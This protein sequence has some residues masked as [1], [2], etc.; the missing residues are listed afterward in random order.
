VRRVTFS[1]F[2]WPRR[3]VEERG[4][5][6]D[7][8]RAGWP[9]VYRT[10]EDVRC[11]P[12]KPRRSAQG[13]YRGLP[14]P[15]RSGRSPDDPVPPVVRPGPR[16]RTGR[17]ERH[18]AVFCGDL[19]DASCPHSAA[20]GVRPSRFAFLHQLHLPEGAGP[21]GR[22][23]GG[24]GVSVV[25]DPTAGPGDRVGGAARRR[26]A[27]P[28]LR[29]PSTR[30]TGRGMGQRASV[31]VGHGTGRAASATPRVR[32]GVGAGRADPPT[33]LLGWFSA[34]AGGG[35]VLAGWYRPDARPFPVS[36]ATG[37]YVADRPSGS[38]TG[39]RRARHEAPEERPPTIVAGQN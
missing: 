27:R 13:L 31:Q 39:C 26:G 8:L 1:K 37:R 33:R 22:P 35:R 16:L 9:H 23:Q 19:R 3:D 28:L 38:L 14:A 24:R 17:T 21:G 25:P 12:P 36:R 4:A 20:E 15:F 2:S 10:R 30:I 34:G 32:R 7:V 29:V 18:G 5:R 6:P 11:G